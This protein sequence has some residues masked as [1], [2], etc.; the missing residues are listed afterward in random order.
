MTPAA[1]PEVCWFDVRAITLTGPELACLGPQERAR[2]A[3]FVFP[4]DR[5]RYQV[6]HVALRQLLSARTGL[7]P[8]QLEFGREPCPRCG[9][10]TG[11]PA[12]AGHR[13]LHFSLSH[14]ADAVVMAISAA[15]VGIDL[16]PM[17]RRCSCDLADTM[18][19][20]DAARVR[21]LPEQQRHSA[22]MRWWVAAEAVLK[23]TGAGIA[24]GMAGFPLLGNGRLR[25][26]DPALSPGPADAV[27]LAERAAG[28]WLLAL[29]A[30]PGY[31]AAIA[32]RGQGAAGGSAKPGPS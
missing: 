12:L 1:A 22:I 4:A 26:G 32:V 24:H 13:G 9:A 19:G 28:C 6:A 10:R 7:P 18:H 21:A 14:S 16:E 17:V 29:T 15:P 30:P 31:V 3:A 5:H 27:G 25:S 20:A 23:C 11:R 2:A 8:G